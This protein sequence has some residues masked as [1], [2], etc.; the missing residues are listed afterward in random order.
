MMDTD[1]VAVCRLLK[2]LSFLHQP[3]FSAM[4]LGVRYRW[5]LYQSFYGYNA[6]DRIITNEHFAKMTFADLSTDL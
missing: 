2:V 5:V 6:V 3:I 1:N 4:P